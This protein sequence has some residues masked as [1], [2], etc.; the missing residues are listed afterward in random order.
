MRN[1]YR[2]YFLPTTMFMCFARLLGR[3]DNQGFFTSAFTASLCQKLRQSTRHITV[4]SSSSSSKDSS[5]IDS[6]SHQGDSN[7]IVFYIPTPEDMEDLGGLLATLTVAPTAIFL[8][9][10]LGAGKTALSRGYLRT[11]TADPDLLVTSPTYLLSN[12]YTTPKQGRVYHMDLYR[13]AQ[14]DS[15]D[16]VRELL[17]PLNLDHIFVHDVALLEWPERMGPAFSQRNQSVIPNETVWPVLPPERLEID[18]R[19][20]QQSKQ[21]ILAKDEKGDDVVDVLSRTVTL[22]P[23]GKQWTSA[24][25]EAIDEGSVDD[26]L[27]PDEDDD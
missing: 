3:R 7:E 16:D 2:R 27:Y 20:K 15:V 9:G 26:F 13:L 21:P 11:A 17:R 22:T 23:V 19:I 25:Q 10:D 6:T 14:K 24:L 5:G 8:D 1:F 18:I 12:V 4:L